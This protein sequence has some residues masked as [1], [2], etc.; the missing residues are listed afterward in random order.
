MSDAASRWG[1]P[2]GFAPV[3]MP[4]PDEIKSQMR[5]LL[6][7]NEPVIIALGNEG[8]SLFLVATTER[9]FSVRSGITAGTSGL[10]VR[11]YSYQ[12]IA[13]LKMLQ[14]PLNVKITLSFHSRDGRKAESGARAKQWKLYTDQLMP[15]E[16][17]RGVQ[18]F[19]ALQKVWVHK[20]RPE[21]YEES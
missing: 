7:A 5:P 6:R 12:E 8:D 16:T 2:E 3:L 10:Q 13:D 18:A 1:L 14:S 21:L 4:L 19:G 17:A 20:T 9:V 11:E 15:F